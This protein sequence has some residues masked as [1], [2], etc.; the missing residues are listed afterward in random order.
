MKK[1][2]P[3]IFLLPLLFSRCQKETGE[4][5]ILKLYGDVFEDIGYSVAIATDGYIIAGQ[6]E[7]VKRENGAIVDGSANK[8]MAVIKTDWQGNLKW[9]KSLGGKKAD[10]CSKIYQMADGSMLC[11]GTFTDTSAVTNYGKEVFVVKLS[12]AGEILWQKTYEEKGNQTGKDIIEAPFGYLII[13]T[14][15]IE[16]VPVTASSGNPEGKTDIFII[17]TDVNGL[18]IDTLRRGFPG[19]EI[20][21]AIKRDGSGNFIILGTTEMPSNPIKK[22]DLFFIKLNAQGKVID[23]KITGSNDDEYSSDIEVLDDGYLVSATIGASGGEQQG[24]ILKLNTEIHS[25]PV[26]EKKFQVDDM[27]TSV[28]AMCPYDQTSYAIAG[29]VGSGLSSKMMVL[30]MDGSGNLVEGSKMIRG[31]N[32]EQVVNDIVSGDDG[33]IIAVG[34]NK[35]DLNSMISFLK[36]KFQNN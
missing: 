31:S 4:S 35:Y 7:D 5:Y 34:K 20:A 36:F 9:K 2:I 13:G 33:Y 18:L 27:S 23:S 8:N 22:H 16:N 19:D 3:F 28:L 25:D 24:Y 1:V 26:F 12:A 11:V 6:F 29:G 21:S 10:Y 15:D 17:S 32:G 30:E 14:T